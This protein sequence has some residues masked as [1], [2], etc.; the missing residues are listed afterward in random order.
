L[1]HHSNIDDL[2]KTYKTIL[3]SLYKNR[4]YHIVFADFLK[5]RLV[6]NFK[7]KAEN[8]FVLTQVIPD[9][10]RGKTDAY[11]SNMKKT[12]YIGLGYANDEKTIEDIINYEERTNLLK[13]NNIYLIL[14]SQERTYEGN[15]IKII[16]GFLS[17]SDYEN[18][19]NMAHGVI[20]IYHKK[21]QYRYSG[22]ITDALNA[23]KQVI[24][25]IYPGIEWF[26]KKYPHNC[27]TFDVISDLFQKLILYKDKSPNMGEY[28]S[29]LEFHSQS[30]ILN[31][32]IT[33]FR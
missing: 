3:F 1:L 11:I 20:I 18:Y 31:E 6:E 28:A 17:R 27:I 23:K 25:R 7:V 15:N 29:F 16:T 12:F 22:S 33:I 8:V 13:K 9:R 5:N 24:G 14:R 4:V 32:L 30:K 10:L 26:S 21:Y 2:K 19:Y